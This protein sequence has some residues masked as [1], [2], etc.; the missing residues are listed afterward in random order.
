MLNVQLLALLV[1]LYHFLLKDCLD[2]LCIFA[3]LLEWLDVLLADLLLQ[4]G[5]HLLEVILLIL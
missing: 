5:R 3:Q 1:L 2:P 4:D